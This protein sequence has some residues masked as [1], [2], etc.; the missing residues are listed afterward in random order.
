MW[1]RASSGG[2]LVSLSIIAAIFSPALE[3]EVVESFLPVLMLQF[4]ASTAD[5]DDCRCPMID[6][7]DDTNSE[8][9]ERV[10]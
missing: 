9:A 4:V 6:G 1:E 8:P 5:C 10:E 2:G 3:L 7:C